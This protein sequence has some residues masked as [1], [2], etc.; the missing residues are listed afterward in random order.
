M[1]GSVSPEQDAVS[2]AVPLIDMARYYAGDA[3][4]KRQLAREVDAACREIGFLTVTGHRIPPA[5]TDS[6]VRV[7]RGFFALPP[8]QKLACR[9]PADTQL[10]GYTPFMAHRLARSRGVEAPPDLREAYSLGRPS[11][12]P[13]HPVADPDAAAFYR[14]NVWPDRPADFRAI[15]TEYYALVDQLAC[16]LMRVFALAL[17]LDESYFDDKIDDHFAALNTFFYPAQMDRPQ[18]GQF[19]AGAHSDFGSLTILLQEENA[20]GLEVMGKYGA[21]HFV[22]PVPGRFVI[23]IG[24]LMAQWTN[25]RWCSTLHRVVNPPGEAVTPRSRV[26]VGFFCHPNFE[27]MIQCLPGCLGA[28]GACKYEPVKA[29]TYMR[30]KILAVRTPPAA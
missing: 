6:V 19:R 27:T 5:L 15:Y 23:N 11:I 14:P 13:G 1:A 10:R 20:G 7:A 17:G 24:D 12:L 18:E 3:A 4:E 21:W 8:E 22:P 30:R 25:D 16:D 2:G 26:S 28:D 29:G 9:G